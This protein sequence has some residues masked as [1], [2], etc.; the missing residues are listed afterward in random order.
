MT[1]DK[2]VGADG[3]EPPQGSGPW[4]PTPQPELWFKLNRNSDFTLLHNLDGSAIIN[5]I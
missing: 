4:K 2:A 5:L 3:G 1:N